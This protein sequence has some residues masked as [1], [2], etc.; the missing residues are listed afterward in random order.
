[1]I[2]NS[3]LIIAVLFFTA[4]NSKK[5]YTPQQQL[6]I[7]YTNCF[8]RAYNDEGAALKNAIETYEDLLIEEGIIKNISGESYVTL[9]E[10]MAAND[11]LAFRPSK[12]FYEYFN[13]VEEPNEAKALL[14]NEQYKLGEKFEKSVVFTQS[15]GEWTPANLAKGVLSE[16][17]ATD[18]ELTFYKMSF[19]FMFDTINYENTSPVAEDLQVAN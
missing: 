8:N 16:F 4:C 13:K 9:F 17:S 18:F 3:V 5:E 12:P 10:K 2:K 15:L 14:C 6:A 11:S 7:A 19:F 1:M